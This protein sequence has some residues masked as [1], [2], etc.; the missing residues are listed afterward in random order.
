MSNES[1]DSTS[2]WL[3]SMVLGAQPKR[4]TIVKEKIQFVSDNYSGKC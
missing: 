1:Y 4:I 2:K 3:W